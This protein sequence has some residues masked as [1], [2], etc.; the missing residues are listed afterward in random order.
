MG[1]IEIRPMPF[2]LTIAR[3]LPA[4]VNSL[5]ELIKERTEIDYTNVHT[6]TECLAILAALDY[7]ER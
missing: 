5:R 4:S 6:V 7:P 3:Y 1:T 2:D